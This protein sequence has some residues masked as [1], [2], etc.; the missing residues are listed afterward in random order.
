MSERSEIPVSPL[1]HR[2]LQFIFIEHAKIDRTQ[3]SLTFIT[4]QGKIEFPSNQIVAIF[5]GPG[6]SITHAAVSLCADMGV[7][8]LWVGDGGVRYYAAGKPIATKNTIGLKQ[9]QLVANPITRKIVV[10]KMYQMRFPDETL[11]GL[12]IKQ[13]MGKEGN[14]VR[15]FYT[16]TAEKYDLKWSNRITRMNNIPEDDTLNQAITLA[17]A[18]LYGI[19][20]AIIQGIGAIPQLGFIHTGNTLSF[21][22]DIADL[23][24]MEYAVETAFKIV[25]SNNTDSNL[26]TIIRQEMR[27][28]F[29]TTKLVKLIIKDIKHLLEIEQDALD[30]A[31]IVYLWGDNDTYESSGKNWGSTEW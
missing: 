9:A 13:M 30:F 6:T 21:V 8:L 7:L 25:S 18:T 19:T 28:L 12:T 17:T 10:Q 4:Q 14:R 31:D 23:Y 22:F 3:S 1:I 26:D 11:E 2:R 29:Y 16:Q 24:K 15:S 5:M 20:N 27:E